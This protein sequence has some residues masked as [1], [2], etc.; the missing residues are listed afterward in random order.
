MGDAALRLN[1]M[2]EARNHFDEA[3]RLNPSSGFAH[4]RRGQLQSRAGLSELSIQDFLDTLALYSGS[5]I[6]PSPVCLAL[7]S[8]YQKLGRNSDADI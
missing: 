3:I 4:F 8:E 5:G 2:D 1:K 7:A 6:T